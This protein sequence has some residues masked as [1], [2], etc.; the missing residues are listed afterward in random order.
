MPLSINTVTYRELACEYLWN[1][2]PRICAGAFL[3]FLLTLAFVAPSF[4]TPQPPR[5]AGGASGHGLGMKLSKPD[6]SRRIDRR[7]YGLDSIPLAASID[8]S[9]SLPPV[10]NQG[11]YS[12]CVG[13]ATGY[14]AKS[15]YEKKEHPT[16]DMT[17]E[18]RQFSPQFVWNGINGGQNEATS[19]YDALRFMEQ[20]GNTDWEQFP[21]EGSNY[22]EQP[23]SQSVEAAKQYKI[24][25]DWGYFFSNISFPN[26]YNNNIS[27][28]KAWLSSGKPV[29]LGIPIYGDFPDFGSNPSSSFYD[30]DGSAEFE[31]GHAVFIAGYNDNAGGPGQGGFLMINSWGPT[32]NGAGRVYLSYDFVA[33]YVPEAWYMSDMDST[34]SLSSI[35]PAGG[36]P[37]Q[38]VTVSGS[39]LGADRRSSRVGFDGGASGQVVSWTNSQ[40]KV[41]VPASARSGVV[42]AYDWNGEKSNGKAFAVGKGSYAAANWLLAEG[43]TWPG[44]DEWVLLQNPNSQASNVSIAFLTPGGPVDGPGVIVPALS[45]T[46]VHVNEY[47]PNADVSTAVTVTS[48]ASIC[49]ERAM[50]F[51]TPDGKWGSHDSIA[52]EGV[53]DTWYLAEGATWPGFDEWILVMNPFDRTVNVSV[54]F[55]TPGGEIVGPELSLAAGTRQSVHVNEYAPNSDVSAKVW[56]TTSGYGIVAERSMYIHTPDG[57]VGCHNSMGATEASGA[58]GLTEG[59][60]WPGYE[61]WVLVANP[62]SKDAVADF[63]FLTPDG[64]SE[65]PA[66]TVPAGRRISV[67]VNDYLPDSD[68][69]TMI[70]TRSE[71]MSVVAERAMYISSP[72]GKRG[73]HN[74]PGSIYSSMDWLLPEGCTSPGFDEWVLVMNPD[75]DV[76]ANVQLTFMTPQGQVEGPTASLPPATRTTFHVNDYVTGDVSTRV[77]SEQYVIAERAMYMNSPQSKTGATCSLGVI[78]SPPAKTHNGVKPKY[79]FCNR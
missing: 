69:S 13:W 15:F 48:G 20:N 34:P 54:T 32:W 50:Y 40:V 67:R 38:L 57:K 66:V 23:N 14:Y 8:L 42:Y 12:S 30:Y 74:A 2:A 31:G 45:R 28:L 21:Y 10:K 61:E 58:W 16:W 53:A 70:F 75:E 55:Q 68:V 4:S 25:D 59:A 62:T 39:N 36:E 9:A 41:R 27:D 3:A 65:G 24:S 37:G 63:F 5:A 43:S 22:A 7:S 35:S 79:A 47:V 71:D 18:R 64:V 56:C 44:F 26:Y 52:A 72:D 49:A 78:T 19:I 11:S 29:V 51:S 46:T 60:T 76:T 33:H 77:T 6:L 1:G 73:A 17:D